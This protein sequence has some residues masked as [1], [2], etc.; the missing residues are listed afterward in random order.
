MQKL[1]GLQYVTVLYLNM[2]YYTIRLSPAIQG[3]TTIVNEFCKFRYNC[4]PMGMCD[5]GDVFQVNVDELLGD[6]K[7]VKTYINDIIV[8]IK[9]SLIK[10][11]R[12]LI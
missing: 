5:L 6:I 12:S 7:G 11:I 3:M 9:L 8:L 10:T 2:R 4:R 1:D